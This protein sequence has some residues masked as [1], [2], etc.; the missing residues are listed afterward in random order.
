M[1]EQILFKVY[2]QGPQQQCLLPSKFLK[3]SYQIMKFSISK[4]LLYTFCSHAVWPWDTEFWLSVN[5]LD[6]L[7]YPTSETQDLSDP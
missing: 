7:H 2:L 6:S 1:S 3:V 5:T 4:V